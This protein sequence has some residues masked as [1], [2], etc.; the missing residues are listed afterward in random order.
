MRDFAQ[1]PG[2]DDFPFQALVRPAPDILSNLPLDPVLLAGLADGVPVGER[3]AIRDLGEDVAFV[4]GRGEGHGG[5]AVGGN[6]DKDD[7]GFLRFQ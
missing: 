1:Q 7:I 3:H 5:L 6:E 2:P 4:P